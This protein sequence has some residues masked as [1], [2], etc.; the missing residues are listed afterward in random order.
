MKIL[1][2]F[3]I[4]L[5]YPRRYKELLLNS[6]WRVLVYA[7]VII[8]V[9]SAAVVTAAMQLKGIMGAYYQK[10]VPDFEFKNNTLT[11][12]EP[13]ELNL[14]GMLIIADTTKQFS[15]DDMGNAVYGYLFDSD[16]MVV[17]SGGR[18][19]EATYAELTQNGDLAFSKD[20]LESYSFIADRFFALMCAICVFISILGFFMGAL[21]IAAVALIPNRNAGLG[22][23]ELMKL[24]VYSRGLP[25]VLSFV[26]SRFIGSLP[27][28]IS[29]AISCIFMN[30]AL[31]NIIKDNFIKNNP[32]FHD[33]LGP[34]GENR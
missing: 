29:L 27:V 13:F 3:A 32:D 7:A 34:N 4:G 30:I 9:S 17:R 24:A 10:S 33:P 1:N 20:T 8:A 19:V 12:S 28:L 21:F 15:A 25:A 18:T 31:M 2:D 6:W 22:F 11:M 14:G 5:V 23:T 16:S 26:L